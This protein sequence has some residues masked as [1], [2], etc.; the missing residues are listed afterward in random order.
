M[1]SCA[2]PPL[3]SLSLSLSRCLAVSLSLCVRADRVCPCSMAETSCIS[4]MKAMANGA[5]PITSRF[6]PS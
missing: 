3:A 6:S 4:A 1:S 5:I 2:T